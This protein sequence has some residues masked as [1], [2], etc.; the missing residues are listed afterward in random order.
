MNLYDINSGSRF[1]FRFLEIGKSTFRVSVSTPDFEITEKKIL[2]IKVPDFDSGEYR[3]F[4]AH[5]QDFIFK[6]LK[7]FA[8]RYHRQVVFN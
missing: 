1:R 3:Y 8:I 7:R 2:L 4:Y 5:K 6:V